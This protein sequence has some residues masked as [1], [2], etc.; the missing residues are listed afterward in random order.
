MNSELFIEVKWFIVIDGNK[1]TRRYK[2]NH[3]KL[4]YVENNMFKQRLNI[5]SFIRHA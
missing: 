3:L 1:A 5:I 2:I 4:T